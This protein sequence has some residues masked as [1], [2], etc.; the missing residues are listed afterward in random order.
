MVVSVMCQKYLSRRQ[1]GYMKSILL[2]SETIFTCHFNEKTVIVAIVNSYVRI[3]YTM[4]L[5]SENLWQISRWGTKCWQIASKVLKIMKNQRHSCK[6]EILADVDN[7]LRNCG[8]RYVRARHITDV[9]FEKSYLCS[10]A[11]LL[12]C[13]LYIHKKQNTK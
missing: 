12:R 9:N 7:D 6:S 4:P 11:T 1:A 3:M 10:S 5:I 8:R 13:C 2:N